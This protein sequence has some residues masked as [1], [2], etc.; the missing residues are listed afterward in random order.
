MALCGIRARARA[1]VLARTEPHV[2]GLLRR[3]LRH[4]PR[5]GALPRGAVR[6]PPLL[7]DGPEPARGERRPRQRRGARD[8]AALP[9]EGQRASASARSASTTRPRSRGAVLSRADRAG[10]PRTSCR[11][12]CT[13]PH[14]N[15]KTGFERSIAIV[16][17][18]G[19]PMDRVLLDH[20]NE[21]TIKITQGPRLLVGVLDLPEHED[22]PARAWSRSSRSTASSGRS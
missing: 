6:H 4:D 9:R 14:R 1:G 12:S 20:G 3:L 18:M 22:G 2:G 13:R 5:L 11:S 10:R 21:E 17:D 7:H 16:R 8:P 19:F 15:K